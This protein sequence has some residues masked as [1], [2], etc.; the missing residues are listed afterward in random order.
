MAQN[1]APNRA[2][3][4]RANQNAERLHGAHL[5][6]G[7]Q[8][9]SLRVVSG[10]PHYTT[11]IFMAKRQ[12]T[13]R[14]ANKRATLRGRGDYADE[15]KSIKS[16]PTR[17]EAKIDHLEKSLNKTSGPLTVNKAAGSIGRV[18]GNFA[19]QGDL[20]AMAGSALAK[21]F[22][23]GDYKVKGNSLMEGNTYARATFSKDGRR[24]TRI[25]ERE[26]LGDIF[27]GPLVGGSTSF[28]LASYQLN[29]TNAITFPWLSRLAPLYDQ[30]DPHGI[31]F[32]FV[33]TSSEFN[34]S[35]QALGTV[36]MATDYD[37][38]DATFTSK[39]AMEN[40][41]YSCSTKPALGLVHGIECDSKERPTPILFT[42]TTNGAPVTAYSLGNFQLA[43]QGCSVANVALGELWV[44]Y[45]ITFYKKQ[46]AD[47]SDTGPLLVIENSSVAVNSG[48]FNG[49]VTT[50]RVI[51]RVPLIGVGSRIDFNNQVIGEK[52]TC[53]IFL[54]ATSTVVDATAL[55]AGAIYTNCILNTAPAALSAATTYCVTLVITTTGINASWQTGLN[56]ADNTSANLAVTKVPTDY[57]LH[58]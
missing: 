44:S 40:S 43:T 52:Y 12:N 37:P 27:S 58:I 39:Q 14:P 54:T 53:C 35:S 15:V 20:G 41:D 32:E 48:Y 34:G 19:G 10:L 24:G 46:L 30:W 7:T 3:Y 6:G 5:A 17:L 50:S 36:V 9:D 2:Q 33:S 8:M 25:T 56:I 51:T 47:N 55:T 45:D 21:Y 13:P 28:T 16:F 29:P 31:V 11:T 38:Y 1:G 4:F 23:H 57:L 49:N 26:Y 18:L 22:G 42:S